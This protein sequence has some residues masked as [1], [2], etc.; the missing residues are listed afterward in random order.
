MTPSHSFS[1]E[2]S[3]ENT[4]KDAPVVQRISPFS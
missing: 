2:R 1:R 3:R 4:V